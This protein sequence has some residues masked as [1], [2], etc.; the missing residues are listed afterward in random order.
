MKITPYKK[1]GKTYYKFQIR[2][3]G[4]VTRR[5]G[6]TSRNQAIYAYAQL[7]EN[8]EDEKNGNIKYERMYEKFLEVYKTKVK[9]STFNATKSIFKLHILPIFGKTKIRDISP[10]QCQQ[11]VI[12]LADYV[13][14]KEYYNQ[15]KRVIDFAKKQR[16]VKEN[17]FDFVILPKFKEGRKEFNFLSPEE[18]YMVI[19][20]HKKSQYWYTLFRV[21]I[22]T[23]LRRGE[24]LALTWSDIDF[25]NREIS[26]TKTLT[27]GEDKKVILSSPKA[28]ASIRVIDIDEETLIE[29]EKLKLKSKSDIVFPNTKGKY[30]RLSNIQDKLHKAC[31]DLGIKNV[32]VHD[33]R[34]TH[35]SLLFAS[36][37]DVK[38]V[39]NRLGHE[40]I[41][42]TLN[43][44]IHV[45][46]DRREENLIN[47]AEYMKKKKSEY[48]SERKRA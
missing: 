35:A 46:K 45:T 9:E 33:L 23:G 42:T 37:A 36:G 40:K 5:A 4:K 26:I 18:S 6:F 29:L 28:K 48:E 15:A 8:Y 7:Q 11:F 13:K 1:N 41:E 22:Y 21:L 38:Y 39:Q 17:P 31:K 44:Y 14:G 12:S 2:L 34:H 19:D 43:I 24:I 10:S 20:H 16:L 32:R 27:I 47:F 30:A 25:K 3:G